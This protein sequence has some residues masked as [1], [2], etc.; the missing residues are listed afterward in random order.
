MI[1]SQTEN[2][3]NVFCTACGS[4]YSS[5]KD[6]ERAVKKKDDCT[7]PECP[8][9]LRTEGISHESVFGIIG[10]ITSVTGISRKSVLQEQTGL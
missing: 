10:V 6:E 1:I 5:S 7:Y 4:S 2:S 3:L 8:Y 9:C